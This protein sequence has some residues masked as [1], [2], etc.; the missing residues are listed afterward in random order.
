MTSYGDCL[1]SVQV[2]ISGATFSAYV[3]YCVREY[4]HVIC[5][6]LLQT[7]DHMVERSTFITKGFY[8][9]EKVLSVTYP[10]Y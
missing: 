7:N 2:K 3:H 10:T 5:V 1:V 6:Y 9:K 8:K 4:M